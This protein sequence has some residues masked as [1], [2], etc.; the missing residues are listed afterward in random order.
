MSASDDE[1]LEST[2]G[3]IED[4]E[5][6][7][8]YSY[9]YLSALFAVIAGG[10]AA[11]VYFGYLTPDVTVTATLSV[12]WVLE[13]AVAGMVALFFL[14]TF[15]QVSNITGMAFISGVVGTVARIADNYELPREDEM[16][17]D[18]G[19]ASDESDGTDTD[20]NA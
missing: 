16:T 12:G 20:S 8:L 1:S 17:G 13:Y 9:A 4:P 11:S 5:G 14:W 15:A 10:L 3:A 19:G 2:V 6:S 18:G 7:K